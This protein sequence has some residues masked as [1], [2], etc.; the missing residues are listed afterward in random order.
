MFGLSRRRPTSRDASWRTQ[1]DQ[2]CRAVPTAATPKSNAGPNDDE[3]ERKWLALLAQTSQT[4]VLFEAIGYKRECVAIDHGSFV[5][6]NVDTARR[7]PR[8]AQLGA[9]P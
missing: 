3:H 2:H 9:R 6:V 1:P 8:L 5:E 4:E 7:Q